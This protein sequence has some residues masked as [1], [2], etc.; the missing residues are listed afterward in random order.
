[1]TD[2]QLV[3]HAMEARSR[4]Y[5]PYSNYSVGAALLLSD[6][7]VILGCNVENATYGETIC[8]ERTAIVSA[9]AAGRRDFKKLA[10]ISSGGEAPCM[11]CVSCRQVMSE[12]APDL[13]VLCARPD[14]L[15][16]ESYPL[17]RL[18]PFSFF[19]RG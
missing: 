6:D 18:L 7:T 8:A 13:V 14:G 19:F 11:P 15:S 9:I 5:C 2:Q 10:V 4:A 1:M 12:F 16:W 17:S 3:R